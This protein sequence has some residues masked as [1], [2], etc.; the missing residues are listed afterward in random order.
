[1]DIKKINDGVGKL[2]TSIR[3][4]E[5]FDIAEKIAVLQSTASLLQN[6]VAAE[7]MKEMYKNIFTTL[8]GKDK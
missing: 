6:T 5:G 1:M 8:L 2:L 3:E 4:L 7:S